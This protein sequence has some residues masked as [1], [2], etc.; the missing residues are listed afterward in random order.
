MG[1]IGECAYVVCVTGVKPQSLII[2]CQLIALF[3]QF[4]W[5]V[6]LLNGLECH[7]MAFSKIKCVV[8]DLQI[9]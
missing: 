5:A 9:L 2:D 3:F 1:K 4:R 6:R 7:E 8:L